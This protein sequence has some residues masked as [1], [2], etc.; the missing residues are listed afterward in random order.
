[1]IPETQ[2]DLITAGFIVGIFLILGYLIEVMV[3]FAIMETLR[4]IE[5]L[6]NKRSSVTRA[7]SCFHDEHPADKQTPVGKFTVWPNHSDTDVWQL[8]HCGYCKRTYGKGYNTM[9]LKYLRRLHA[10][11]PHK[12]EL[13]ER[14]Y[15]S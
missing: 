11:E 10:H 13:K 8:F 2:L 5:L 7:I 3:G 6:W 12:E 1:M 4:A 14:C 15:F 9:D